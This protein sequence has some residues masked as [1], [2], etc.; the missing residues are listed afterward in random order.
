MIVMLI[1]LLLPSISFAEILAELDEN[2]ITYR[3]RNPEDNQVITF[4]KTNVTVN[5]VSYSYN[6]LWQERILTKR[7]NRSF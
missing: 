6:N 4:S 7:L 2:S 3:K 5:G 1:A